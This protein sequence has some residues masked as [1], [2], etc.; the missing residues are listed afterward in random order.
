MCCCP[1]YGKEYGSPL[2]KM[3]T[4]TCR[5]RTADRKST[6]RQISKSAVPVPLYLIPQAL[7]KEIR[8]LKDTIA[9]IRINR[10]SGHNY[11]INLFSTAKGETPSAPL[12]PLEQDSTEERE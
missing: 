4:H 5:M 7:A 1:L 9:E 3:C 6:S 8:E 2:N 12:F 11:R 10:T